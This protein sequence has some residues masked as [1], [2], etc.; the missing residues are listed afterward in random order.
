MFKPWTDHSDTSGSE[1]KHAP[2]GARYLETGKGLAATSLYEASAFYSDLT[3]TTLPKQ[4]VMP[5]WVGVIEVKK[6]PLPAIVHFS[7]SAISW[8]SC[9][10]RSRPAVGSGLHPKDGSR[11]D[12]AAAEF[13]GEW[14]QTWPPK[15][16]LM[17]LFRIWSPFMC[18]WFYLRPLWNR[19]NSSL[20]SCSCLNPAVAK[21]HVLA[22]SERWA[23][24]PWRMTRWQDKE[25]REHPAI[26]A[27]T[28]SMV[29][30]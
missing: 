10:P 13:V 20:L 19:L 24:I 3:Q 23:H 14:P 1:K 30:Q 7:R 28:S 27:L 29:V 5:Q 17:C 16:R 9:G 8:F 11:Q 21:N 25:S 18:P 26:F 15:N 2:L 22:S 4:V 6:P 12:G